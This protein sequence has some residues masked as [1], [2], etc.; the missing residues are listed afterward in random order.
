M[1][2]E[3]KEGSSGGADGDPEQDDK[4]SDEKM[5]VSDI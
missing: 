4:S 5:T 2:Y 1:L 3:E